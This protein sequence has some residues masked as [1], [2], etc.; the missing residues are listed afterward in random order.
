MKFLIIEILTNTAS[1]RNPEF[2]NFHKTLPLPPP[3]TLI[4]LAG[5]AMGLTPKAAQEFFEKSEFCFGVYGFSFG[6]A[7]DI[8]KYTNEVK[9]AKLYNHHPD[10]GGSVITREI[11][12]S[13]RFVVCFG[14][15]NQNALNQLN[16]A[17]DNPKFALTVGNSDSLAFIKKIYRTEVVNKK[18]TFNNC[19]IEGDVIDNV[20]S[21][22]NK[23]LEFS[24]YQTAEPVVYDL[25]TRFNYSEDYGI[26]SVSNVS[27]FSI[28]TKEIKLNYDIEC[29]E[30]GNISI[31]ICK[32]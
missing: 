7:K 16:T 10:F 25:P 30:Y 15:N 20:L 18:R 4:G 2:Q 3:T 5:A 28:I 32:L 13:N 31:P 17:F 1:F 11:L 24:I 21:N 12:F 22:P 26:R 14:S 8:W 9:G 19:V 27:T 6:K 23:S 29:V